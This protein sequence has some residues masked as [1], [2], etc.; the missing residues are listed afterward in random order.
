MIATSAVRAGLK[1]PFAACDAVK[2][3]FTASDE[4]KASFSPRAAVDGRA[5]R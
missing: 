2:G 5:V 4:G 3:A 1:G